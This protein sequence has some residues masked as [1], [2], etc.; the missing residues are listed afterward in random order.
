MVEIELDHAK[1]TENQVV[2]NGIYPPIIEKQKVI[3]PCERSVYHLLEQYSA[4]EKGNPRT[5]K[6]TEKAHATTFKKKFQPMYLENFF[7]LL[8]GLDGM[9][10]KFI[11]ITYLNKNV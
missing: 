4:N 3:D 10:Q 5:Y 2:Y 11:H 6:A 9:L 7:L 1:T 8:I